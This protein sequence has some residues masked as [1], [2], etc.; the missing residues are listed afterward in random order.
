MSVITTYEAVEQTTLDKVASKITA[1]SDRVVLVNLE[2]TNKSLGGIVIPD[3]ATKEGSSKGVVV[4]VGPGKTT[5]NGAVKAMT[6]KKSQVVY[7]SKYAGTEVNIEG[8]KVVIL[9]EDDLLAIENQ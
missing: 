4:A 2:A 9:K 5:E 6:V 1:L 8:V 3:S 7:Y